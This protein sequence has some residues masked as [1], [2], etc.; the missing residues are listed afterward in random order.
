MQRT[1]LDL[2]LSSMYAPFFVPQYCLWKS[3][4][5]RIIYLSSLYLFKSDSDRWSTRVELE[6]GVI[7]EGK[8]FSGC[9]RSRTA[10]AGF[11]AEFTTKRARSV[12]VWYLRMQVCT[13][14]M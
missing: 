5:C 10:S 2:A 12:P 9:T 4:R 1:R 8:R 13:A 11:A 7:M 6:G 3:L 14:A